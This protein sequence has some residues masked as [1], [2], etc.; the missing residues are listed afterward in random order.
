MNLSK[1]SNFKEPAYYALMGG[2]RLRPI[3][4]LEIAR[5]Y[6]SK[7]NSIPLALSIEYLHSS[8][9]I[10]DDMPHFDNDNIRRNKET[11]H[12]KYGNDVAHLL[13]L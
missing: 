8:S 7:I 3:L 2:K 13:A 11:V 4:L 5:H 6:K 1:L 9:L 10:I 12:Y